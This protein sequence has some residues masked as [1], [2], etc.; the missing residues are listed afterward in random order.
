MFF[1]SVEKSSAKCAM[2]LTFAR[3]DSQVSYFEPPGQFLKQKQGSIEKTLCV[4]LIF[5]AMSLQKLPVAFD[6]GRLPK[7]SSKKSGLLPNW[8][9]ITLI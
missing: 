4:V 5:L 3:S 1:S 7:K 2:N 8:G 6:K 9:G